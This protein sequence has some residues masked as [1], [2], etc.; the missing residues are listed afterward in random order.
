MVRILSPIARQLLRRA[1][2]GLTL[3]GRSGAGA[4]TPYQDTLVNTYGADEVWPLVDIASGTTITAAVN[5][6]RNGTLSGWDLQNTAGPRTGTLAPLSGGVDYGNILT[7]SLNGI[8]NGDAGG[9]FIWGKVQSWTPAAAGY[10]L[11]FYVDANNFIA[12]NQSTI[13]NRLTFNRK[14]AG[15]QQII[16]ADSQSHAG[17][18]S[19]GFTWD[20]GAGVDGERKAFVNGTQSGATGNALPSFASNTLTIAAIGNSGVA[21]ATAALAGW[22]A[23]AAVKFGAAWTPT[24]IQEMHAAV[25]P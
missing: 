4:V 11:I 9:I 24:Q 1:N 13:A 21:G 20:T 18:F 8:F 19:V 16:N 23:Y 12:V 7:A 2:D 5:A 10:F 3:H 15:A 14:A 22:P 17:W 25:N 6:A